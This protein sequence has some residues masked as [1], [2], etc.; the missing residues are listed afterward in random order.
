MLQILLLH[1]AAAI[2]GPIAVARWGRRVFAILALA[3]ASAV[4]WALTQ[5]SDVLAGRSPIVSTQWVALLDLEI[6]FR[7]DTLSWFMVLIVGSV[8]ALVLFYCAWYFSSIA[9]GLPRFAGVFVAFAGAMLGL[10]TTD[11]TL[12]LYLFWELTTVFSYLLIGHYNERKVSRRAAM[13]AILVTTFGG[14]AMLGGLILLGEAEGGSYSLTALVSNPPAMTTLT[15]VAIICVLVGALSKSAIVPLHFWLPAAMAAPTP[16]SAYLHA[17]AM[18]K[19]GVYLVARLAPGFSTWDA[20]QWPLLILAGATMI[21]GGYRAL[22]QWDLKLVLAYGTVSQLGLLMML[23]GQPD[24]GVALAGIAMLGSHAMFKATLFLTVGIVD[25]AAGTR[26]IHQLSNLRRSMPFLSVIAGLAVASMIGIPPLAGYVAKEAA[27]EGLVHEGGTRATAILVVLVIGSILTVA[28][29]LRFWWGAFSPKKDLEDT[30][31]DREAWQ[32]FLPPALLAAGGLAAGL[33]PGLGERLLA[34]YANTYPD[35]DAGHLTLWGGF[36]LPLL[37]TV[38]V[39]ALGAALFFFRGKDSGL[40][41]RESFAVDAE[42]TYRRFMRRLDRLAGFAT[43][44]T[45]RGSLPFYLSAILMVMVLATSTALIASGGPF[46]PVRIWDTPVQLV[47]GAIVVIAA[48][49]AARSRRRLK[50]VLLIGISGYGVALLYEI[51]GA[52]DLA[53]TQVLV[54]TV[55]LVVF[56]LVLRRLPPYFSNRPLAANRWLR[57][58]LGAA[59]G[60]VVAGMAL[61]TANSR[62]ATPVSADFPELAYVYGYGKN[63]VNVTLVDIRAWDTMGEI[64]V[65]LVAATGVASLI[66]LRVRTQKVERASDVEVDQIGEVWADGS[67]GGAAGVQLARTGLEGVSAA[68]ESCSARSANAA[69]SPKMPSNATGQA[70]VENA[71]ANPARRFTPRWNTAPALRNQRWLSAGATLAPQRRSV[72]LEIATRLLFHT[73]LVFSVFLLFSGHNAPGGGFAGGL[74]AG[75]ALVV[76]YL[77]GGRYELG[78][79]APINAGVLLGSGLFLSAGAGLVPVFFGGTVLQSAVIEFDGGPFG[80]VKFVTTLFF[81]IGVYLVVIGVVLD[82]LRTLGAEIDR[83]AEEEGSSA[84]EIGF[85]DSDEDDSDE[86][87]LV[88]ADN[89]DPWIQQSGPLHSARPPQSPGSSNG[90]SSEEASS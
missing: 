52:P 50:A 79:A 11:S 47:V 7:L 77:A 65:L 31:V 24:R 42:E 32:M 5:T 37:L 10:V 90:S 4:V 6:S 29:G 86:P 36:G 39:L 51:H 27:L 75:I 38:G 58:I 59:V 49:L 33:I 60:I 46:G 16:V 23:V 71:D 76:R 17:A 89:A 66:F 28:Y 13:Q 14:L 3:P 68:V 70:P 64:S 34:P 78:E 57:G 22:R 25:A 18:V 63:I 40:Q 21:L 85:D 44:L 8:G 54:E 87:A 48:I 15:S 67:A 35:G 62:I 81:D 19:A 69:E 12:M 74:V 2:V 84:P 9:S 88:G 26:D 20:W 1:V 30:A 61:V 43:S 83:Q 45:Q 56:V 55:T 73:M 41:S 82:L 72:M 80:H 53:L